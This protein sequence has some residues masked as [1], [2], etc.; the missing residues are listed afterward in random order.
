MRL[1]HPAGEPCP[2]GCDGSGSGTAADADRYL[3]EGVIIADAERTARGAA[4]GV[5]RSFVSGD[6]DGFVDDLEPGAIFVDDLG[7]KLEG[8]ERELWIGTWRAVL[9]D[10][11]PV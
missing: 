11:S 4:R 6:P 7:R 3:D 5:W 9:R 2:D 8:S 10:S 1:C